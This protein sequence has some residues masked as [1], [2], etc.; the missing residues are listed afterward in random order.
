MA[1]SV[2]RLQLVAGFFEICGVLVDVF[3]PLFTC[4]HLGAIT[5]K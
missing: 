5:A 2:Y 1:S 3:G 4:G